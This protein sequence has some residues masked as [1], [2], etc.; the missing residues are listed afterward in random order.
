MKRKYFL[1]RHK[2]LEITYKIL[3]TN[4]EALMA[5]DMSD[6]M[7][8]IFSA[9]HLEITQ[10]NFSKRITT[11]SELLDALREIDSELRAKKLLLHITYP[12]EVSGKKIAS[13]M[14]AVESQLTPYKELMMIPSQKHSPKYWQVTLYVLD[15]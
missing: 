7:R 13:S 2:M 9:R 1:D 8:F 14:R 3:Q 15:E 10:F 4:N 12:M 5:Y 11:S 6:I